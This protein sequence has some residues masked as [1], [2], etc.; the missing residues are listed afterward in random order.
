MFIMDKGAGG[1]LTRNYTYF[2]SL[3]GVNV[4]PQAFPPDPGFQF[5]QMNLSNLG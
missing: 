4:V 1:A 2:A 3:L 5:Q